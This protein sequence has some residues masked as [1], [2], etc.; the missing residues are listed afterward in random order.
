MT[1]IPFFKKIKFTFTFLS[2]CG[3]LVVGIFSVIYM[4]ESNRNVIDQIDITR[5]QK[6]LE[7]MDVIV[8]DYRVVSRLTAE[9]LAENRDIIQAIE[10][11]NT[12]VLR[13][14]AEQMIRLM[15][16]NI[17]FVVFTDAQGNVIVRTNS[18][19][20]GDSINGQRNIVQ[21]LSGEVSSYIEFGTVT[22]LSM[23]TG[24]PVKDERGEVIGVVSAG[25][26][27]VNT[28]FVDK[29]K[30][31]TGNEFTVFIGDERVNTTIMK[32]GRR[33]VGTKLDARI[34][35]AVLKEGMVYHGQTEILDAP[36]AAAYKPILDP[37]G[38]AIGVFFA[39]VPVAEINAMQQ[40]SVFTS[41]IIELAL[42][43]LVIAVLLFLVRRIIT[44]PLADMAQAA[45]EIT[46]G[47]LNVTIHHRSNNELGILAEALRTMV[48]AL[49]SNIDGL[50]RREEDLMIALH[51]AER[52]EQAKS[53][54][55]ANMSHEIRTPMNAI[56]G[57]SYLTLKTELS[58]KQQ[59]YIGKIHHSATSL[60]GIIN[61]ILDFSKIDSGKMNIENIAFHLESVIEDSVVFISRQAQEKGL[62]FVCRISPE[63]PEYIKGDPMRLTEIITNLAGNAVKFTERGEISVEVKLT[64]RIENRV[65][66]QFLVSDTGI[67]ITP[68]QQETLFQ[69]FS[70]ADS[71]TTRRFGGTGL[72]LAISKGLAE[73]MGGTLEVSSRENIGSTF[74]F[75]VWFD[76]E[77]DKSE[78]SKIVPPN[79]LGKKILVVDSNQMVRDTLVEYLRALKFRA[80]SVSS[81]EQ[82][83]ILA[84]Q[85]DTED[86]F[87]VIL[88]NH[89]MEGM[90]GIE[91]AMTFKDSSRLKN[92]PVI[93]L[94]TGANEEAIRQNP[95]DQY[96]DGIL[97][98]PVSQSML[99]DFLVKLFAPEQK[100]KNQRILVQ[101]KKYDLSGFKVL[102]A[103]DNDINLQIAVELLES[104]GMLVDI[105]EDGR[106][107]VRL[108]EA[109]PARSYH[110]ILMDLQMPEMDGFEAT[111]SI[112]ALDSEV[113][114]IAM[115]AR[116]MTDEKQKCFE[117]GMN[118]HI[119]KPIDVDVL[120]STISKWLNV[121]HE[122][123]KRIS[124]HPFP[125][126][127]GVDIKQGLLRAAGNTK[128]YAEL[129]LR[130]AGQQKELIA[131]IRQAALD[132]D[133]AE[134]GKLMH[135]LKGAAGNI[136]AA[137]GASLILQMEKRLSMQQESFPEL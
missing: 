37:E 40:K 102:L 70:Q 120:F 133:I 135:T 30:N 29:M 108:F 57:M 111:K 49:R 43:A 112:R 80:E 127:E 23:R 59:D 32:E 65:R 87:R 82:A 22:R 44:R 122:G 101:E 55:L 85:A 34:A 92:S 68:E 64:G 41:V 56:I 76:M 88:M 18:D 46:H 52:A 21:A 31:I 134:A 73:L 123:P 10:S 98:K 15:G 116:T 61:D 66:L 79:L 137:G 109:A 25:H 45:E 50:R 63:I 6:A 94:L 107:A 51:Q 67:G 38:N 83:I 47:D 103:E 84:E 8:D 106:Q 110:L 95:P 1:A 89:Y 74:I 77:P 58:P 72:G 9:R 48:A 36:Y 5:S 17:D 91:A 97:E 126:I 39:G 19:R 90:D 11:G 125:Q 60:I 27:L 71:S 28:D 78:T 35:E 115:T 16:P 7:T 24:A 33:A 130:F 131:A 2:V 42:M 114:V 14:T 75:S 118:D 86:P 20:S 69:A 104:Q 12:V 119:A 54:F 124:H 99:Y 4:S 105:A 132:G 136:G 117:A 62:E 3:I 128:L 93:V 26:S 113:P 100:N 13:E 96:I 53:Q 129:L 121:H 81:G